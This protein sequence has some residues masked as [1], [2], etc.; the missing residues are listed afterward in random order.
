MVLEVVDLIILIIWDIANCIY[1]L[2]FVIKDYQC[3]LLLEG[4]G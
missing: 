2:Y 3:I 4:F 1:L